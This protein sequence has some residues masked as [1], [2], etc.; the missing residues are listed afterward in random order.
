MHLVHMMKDQPIIWPNTVSSVCQ[1]FL[2][3]LLQKNPL[4]R[5]TWPKL[6]EHEFVK[7]RVYTMDQYLDFDFSESSDIVSSLKL[8]KINEEDVTSD[9]STDH[10]STSSEDTET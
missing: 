9:S 3:Q 5:L 4:E 6:L 2:E 10:D 8:M 1:N 7:N